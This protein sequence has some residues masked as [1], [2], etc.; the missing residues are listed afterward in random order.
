MSISVCC[1]TTALTENRTVGIP[2]LVATTGPLTRPFV[3][4]MVCFRTE[5]VSL[6]ITIYR[7][8]LMS[9]GAHDWNMQLAEP[10]I[11]IIAAPWEK[12]FSRRTPTLVK[13]YATQT[14]EK[15]TCF[16]KAVA[17]QA[18]PSRAAHL[19]LLSGQLNTYGDSLQG[20]SC[21][22]V[23]CTEALICGKGTV[24]DL[25]DII[26]T[27]QREINREF[28]PVIMAVMHDSYSWC[29]A[30]RGP[31]QFMRMKEC[32]HRHA[33]SHKTDMFEQS[34][35]AVKA[36]L[37]QL[38]KRVEDGMEE[39]TMGLYADMQKDYHSIFGGEAQDFSG[40]A[41]RKEREVK[42]TLKNALKDFEKPFLLVVGQDVK[43][44]PETE[45][46]TAHQVKVEDIGHVNGEAKPDEGK[47]A[48]PNTKQ[49]N[50]DAAAL[51]KEVKVKDEIMDN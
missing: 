48:E 26:N 5:M 23:I 38:V 49:R 32:M 2:V 46:E 51:M 17:D 10:M 22:L 8:R 30:E 12:V 40:G 34:T 27:T 43:E 50:Q 28:T 31:G 24:N 11:R 42:N 6:F 41:G 25:V 29:T 45:I 20:K 4:V 7:T 13:K 15:I 18:G 39:V 9:I 19:H 37:I 35:T 1:S 36:R 21:L 16:H 47:S 33:E 3:G 44:D 14:R